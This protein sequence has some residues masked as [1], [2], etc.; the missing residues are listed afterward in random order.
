MVALLGAKEENGDHGFLL[1]FL[2]S[3]F[4]L[5]NDDVEIQVYF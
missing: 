5:L 4:S 1:L 3:L 2:F